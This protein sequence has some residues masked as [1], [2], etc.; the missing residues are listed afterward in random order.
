MGGV[1]DKGDLDQSS[2]VELMKSGHLWA[3]RRCHRHESCLCS[4]V[5]HEENRK[6]GKCHFFLPGCHG[7]IY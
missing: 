3:Y 4:H 7:A 6:K 5:R 2:S 1:G